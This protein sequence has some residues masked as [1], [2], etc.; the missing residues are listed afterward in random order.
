M[1]FKTHELKWFQVEKEEMK[2]WTGE[3]FYIKKVQNNNK[4]IQF[5]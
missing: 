1:D 4:K 5:A 3:D 2:V